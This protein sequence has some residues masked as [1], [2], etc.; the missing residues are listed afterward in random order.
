[1]SALAIL[2]IVLGSIL[3]Y[4]VMAATVGNYAY[5]HMAT[6]YDM[7]AASMALAVFWPVTIWFVLGWAFGT[8]PDNHQRREPF[9]WH[10]LSVKRAA[11]VGRATQKELER[12]AAVNRMEDDLGLIRTRW[13]DAP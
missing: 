7:D 8:Q 13:E 12:R 2:G 11:R 3:T 5:N 9:L 1:M 6:G 4:V 10:H